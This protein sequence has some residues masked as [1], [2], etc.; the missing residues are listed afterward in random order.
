MNQRKSAAPRRRAARRGHRPARSAG[1]GGGPCRDGRADQASDASAS[2]SS[3]RRAMLAPHGHSIHTI[4]SSTPASRSPQRWWSVKKASS[5]VSRL[6]AGRV[7]QQAR[8]HR[9]SVGFGRLHDRPLRHQHAHGRRRSGR[10]RAGCACTITGSPRP[11]L[12]QPPDVRIGGP[13]PMRPGS[14]LALRRAH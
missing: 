11:C 6:S 9:D 7:P 5:L 1:S 3:A 12:N 4:A 13:S 8:V 2:P 14:G 10:L